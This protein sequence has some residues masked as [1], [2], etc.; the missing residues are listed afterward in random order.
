[1]PQIIGP[2]T[3]IINFSLTAQIFPRAW[4]IANV[5]PV[6]KK[7]NSSLPQ[8]FRPISILPVF[9]KV[10][11]KFLA[12][13][14]IRHLEDHKLLTE[15]QSGFRKNHSCATAMLKVIDDIREKYDNGEITIL[16]LLD[17]S[18]PLN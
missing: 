6:A 15:Y 11:E 18:M 9:S 12:S 5:I 13:Q 4:K 8:D 16:V 17:F 2:L 1:M 10:Y 7:K 3:H 14:I